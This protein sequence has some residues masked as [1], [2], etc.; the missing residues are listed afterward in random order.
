[1]LLTRRGFIKGLAALAS[2]PAVAA[3]RRDPSLEVQ[4]FDINVDAPNPP[5]WLGEADLY[6]SDRAGDPVRLMCERE[7]V[8][9][10]QPVRTGKTEVM[11]RQISHAVGRPYESVARELESV[12]FKP[13]RGE[14]VCPERTP[15]RCTSMRRRG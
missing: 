8:Y 9:V 13:S 14:R 3:A 1:M 12:S 5:L 10:V 15:P 7:R 6:P 4:S 2:L 11:L